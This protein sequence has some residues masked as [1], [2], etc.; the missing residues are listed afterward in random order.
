[1]MAIAYIESNFNYDAKSKGGN[2]VGIFQL[3]NGYGGCNGDDRLD[4]EKSIIA[5]WKQHNRYKA[6]WRKNVSKEWHPFYYYGIHQKGFTGFVEIYKNRNKLL[7][8]ISDTRCWSIMIS[9]PK[10]ADWHSVNDWWKYFENKFYKVYN[11][12]K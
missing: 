9:K 12:Y 4:I 8:E 11:Q 10:K 5:V 7:T 3:L 2:C 6:R 1:M